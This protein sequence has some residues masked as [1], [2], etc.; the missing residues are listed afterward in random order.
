MSEQFEKKLEPLKYI[1]SKEFEAE[2]RIDGRLLKRKSVG[3]DKTTGTSDIADDS[4]T[5][6][7]IQNLA[8]TEGKLAAN[9]VAQAKLKYE[10]VNVNV[11]AGQ[12]QGTG[13][14]TSGSIIIGFYPAGNVDQFVD[15]I[16]VSGTTITVTLGAAATAQNN[17][18]IVLLKS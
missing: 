2:S 5:T 9:A 10:V 7:M 11:S 8:V 3:G 1:E 15:S 16:S 4:I 18:T 13:T 17:F 14:C 6:A 12:T